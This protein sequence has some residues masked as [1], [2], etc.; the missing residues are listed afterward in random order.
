MKPLATTAFTGP[1]YYDQLLGPVTFAPFAARL[2]TRLPRRPPGDV[3]EL[4]CG[5]GLLTRALR[6]ALDPGLQLVATDLNANMLDY[7]RE[8]L[9]AV[10][11][12]V[13]QPA[14]MMALPFPD[15]HFGAVASG[16]GIMFA[17]DKL[18]A[19]RESRRVLAPGGWLLLSVWD[20][21]EENTASHVN[22]LVVEE[23]F[24]GDPEIRFRL[25]YEMHDAEALRALLAQAGFG[26][27]AID[28][29]RFDYDDGDPLAIATGQMRGTPRSALIEKKGVALDE[30][31]AKIAAALAAKGG[32]PYRGHSQA[33][34]VKARAA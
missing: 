17:P 34:L 10:P 26:D 29:E 7:A 12:I 2:A 27:V 14:D 32:T 4:A 1:R 11:G 23:M 15:A 6:D 13:F 3:L 16:F 18:A 9:A 25:P 24:P 8:Q 30:V 33:L 31:I 19:L 28:T 22:S 20:R 5:T 21:I